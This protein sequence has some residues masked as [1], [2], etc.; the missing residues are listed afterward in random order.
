M[1]A[2]YERA[3]DAYEQA[4]TYMADARKPEDVR[5][6]T[7]AVEDGPLQLAQLAAR[8]E[9]Q[10]AARTPA[11]LLLRPAPRP[12][13]RG[14]H[15]DPAGRRHPPGPGVRRRSRPGCPTAGIR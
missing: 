4:K 5:A 1:R 11:A 6:V 2:D 9:G 3:L 10:A 12:V 15:L 8:R 14:R 13:G 7:Q